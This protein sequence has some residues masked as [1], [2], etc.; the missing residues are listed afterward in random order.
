MLAFAGIWSGNTV[1]LGEGWSGVEY[2]PK[3]TIVMAAYYISDW[4]RTYGRK[5]F[6]RTFEL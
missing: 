5:D 1:L 4:I 6:K 3:Y 2:H